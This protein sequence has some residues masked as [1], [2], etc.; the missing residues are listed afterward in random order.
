MEGGG[1]LMAAVVRYGSDP[2]VEYSCIK[3]VS[4][5]CVCLVINHTH[6]QSSMG[7]SL[8]RCESGTSGVRKKM[9]CTLP[10]PQGIGV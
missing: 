5:Q 1:A 8:L 2:A 6:P 9:G 4:E 10:T 3:V 7:D